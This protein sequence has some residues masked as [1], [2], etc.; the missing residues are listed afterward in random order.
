MGAIKKT[1]MKLIIGKKYKANHPYSYRQGEPFTVIGVQWLEN[2]YTYLIMFDDR[3]LDR[4]PVD[5]EGGYD[6]TEV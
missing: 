3:E 4:I 6:I 1:L 2:R 5:N